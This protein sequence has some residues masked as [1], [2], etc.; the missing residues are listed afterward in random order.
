[1]KNQEDFQ[2]SIDIEASVITLFPNCHRK[3]HNGLGEDVQEM[4]KLLFEKRKERLMKSGI[5]INMK[6]LLINCN[7]LL[8]LIILKNHHIRYIFLSLIIN[9]SNQNELSKIDN[10]NISVTDELKREGILTEEEFTQPL[11]FS[12]TNPVT[13]M[14]CKNL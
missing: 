14:P 5:E 6:Q 9:K 12:S 2:Y 1:M 13:T 4:L 10:T 3:L 7:F 8:L 11:H